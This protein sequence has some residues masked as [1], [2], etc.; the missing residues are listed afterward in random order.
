MDTIHY[1]VPNSLDKG[2]FGSVFYYVCSN[3]KSHAYIQTNENS[4]YPNWESLSSILEK[5]FSPLITNKEF[6]EF[7]LEI[8]DSYTKKYVL[9]NKSHKEQQ[10]KKLSRILCLN[11]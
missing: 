8:S 11:K 2:T 5:A 3:N 4:M 1:R 6:L 9:D 10:F 7:C